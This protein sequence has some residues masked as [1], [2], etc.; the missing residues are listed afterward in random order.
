MLGCTTME[1]QEEVIDRDAISK[2]ISDVMKNYGANWTTNADALMEYYLESPE[3]I[4]YSDGK[5]L[6]YEDW[7]KSI[8]ELFAK[9]ITYEGDPYKKPQIRVLCPEAAFF[10]CYLDYYMTDSTGIKSKVTGA[11]TYILVKEE[12]NWQIIHGIA[13]HE[14]M[15]IED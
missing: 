9:G 2:E 11:V 6:N 3:F 7:D 5:F 8:H 13:D 10:T 14:S 15:P 12:D 1:T 4:F